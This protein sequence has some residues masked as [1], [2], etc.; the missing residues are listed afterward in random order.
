MAG[1]LLAVPVCQ[2]AFGER[3]E[4]S[5]PA[6]AIEDRDLEARGREVRRAVLG[7]QSGNVAV[8]LRGGAQRVQT[9][10]LDLQ[11]VARGA[12]ERLDDEVEV[13]A[14]EEHVDRPALGVRRTL[15]ARDRRAQLR[16]EGAHVEVRQG[17]VDEQRE[18]HLDRLG[19]GEQEAVERV[20]AS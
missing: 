17:G 12:G 14:A 9:E 7:A 20:A 5:A 3:F 16:V 1:T 10:D 2:L 18:L 11:A 13:E 8:G 15:E 4:A 19:G 6:F